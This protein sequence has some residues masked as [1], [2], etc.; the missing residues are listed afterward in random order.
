M[1]KQD[2]HR[3]E[4]ILKFP[5]DTAGGL[6]STDTVTIRPDVTLDV[7]LRY[8]RFNDAL[9]DTTDKLFVVNRADKLLGALTLSKLVTNDPELTVAEVFSKD[10]SYIYAETE[11]HEVA[12]LFE[13]RDL[14]S[15]PVVDSDKKLLG[16]I[17]IDDVVDV[18]RDEADHSLMS[19]AG[20]DEE[21]DLFSPAVRSSRRRSVWLGI[22][23]L[24]ALLAS[25]VISKF[26]AT[27]E[28]MVALAILMP[29]VASMGG[30]AG[31]QTLTL[32]IRGLAI[33]QVGK[34]NAMKLLYK[35]ILVGLLN[36]TIWATII[37]SLAYYWF[38]SL[39]LGLIIGL[40][41]LF[42]LIV[43]SISGA[44]IPMLLQKYGADPALGGGVVLTTITDVVGFFAFLGL[45]T[46]FLI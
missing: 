40:A 16:R 35:E 2:R 37:G 17:T 1:G 13:K 46:L 25:W 14:V 24:T 27:I 42:N 19:L 32:V 9:P 20:L 10:I 21:D 38:D 31:S 5:D 23:L 29:I 41:I 7:V 36:G 28:Q 6:M 11:E 8:L 33:G 18:I 44:T 34:S 22:N 39:Q 12:H 3:L 43:A 4:S 26:S 30:I 45:A 15:A